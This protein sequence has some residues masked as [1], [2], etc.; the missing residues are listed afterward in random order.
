M[1]NEVDMVVGLL[2]Y[3]LISYQDSGGWVAWNNQLYLGPSTIPS[4]AKGLPRLH[5][6]QVVSNPE[7]AWDKKKWC[8]SLCAREGQLESGPHHDSGA[9][10]PMLSG[11]QWE[12]LGYPLFYFFSHCF[13]AETLLACFSPEF[14]SMLP[15]QICRSPR[16]CFHELNGLD[17][18]EAC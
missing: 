5:A 4:E 12:K 16:M 2:V 17:R 10:K 1:S 7:I 6:T 13:D 15:S 3:G 11:V 9:G 14:R 8:K 18:S